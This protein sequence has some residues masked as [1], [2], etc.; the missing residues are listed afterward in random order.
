ML[1]NKVQKL[2]RNKFSTQEGSHDWFHIERVLKMSMHLHD[3]EGGDKEVIQLA[4]LLHDI[5]DHKYNGGD[6]EKGK[7]EA[8]QIITKEGGNQR[9][10]NKV[11]DIIPQISFVQSKKIIFLELNFTLKKVIK[12]DLK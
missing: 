6:F 3:A 9:L 10:A 7:E 1:I 8:Y 12:W 4:A 5:S 11:A 2:V